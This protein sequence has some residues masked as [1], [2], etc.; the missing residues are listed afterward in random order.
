MTHATGMTLTFAV[1]S[2]LALAA[3]AHYGF[4]KDAGGYSDK[5]YPSKQGLHALAAFSLCILAV[6][7]GVPLWWALAITIADGVAFEFTQ[8]Y[9]NLHDIAADAVGALLAVGL[10]L[11][12]AAL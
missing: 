9:V 5:F 1:L 12:L 10:H 2:V 7:I 4:D 8:G 6:A 11:A 3:N